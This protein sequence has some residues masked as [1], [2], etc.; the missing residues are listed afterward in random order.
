V[1]VFLQQVGRWLDFEDWPP[2]AATATAYYLRG[3]GGLSLDGEPGH[4]APDTFIYDPGPPDAAGGRP[5]PAA[6]R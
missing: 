5:P 1:R 4:A 2:P 3:A 6:A